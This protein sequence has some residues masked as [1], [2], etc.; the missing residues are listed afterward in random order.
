MR[1]AAFTFRAGRDREGRGRVPKVV[2]RHAGEPGGLERGD[3]PHPHR[4]GGRLA[5]FSRIPIEPATVRYHNR[6]AFLMWFMPEQLDELDAISG[7]G[8]IRTVMLTAGTPLARP[9]YFC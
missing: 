2:D 5:P 1:C 9:R 6:A 8:N 3:E 4:T 7:S